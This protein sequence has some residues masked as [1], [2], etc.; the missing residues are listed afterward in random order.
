MDPSGSY[1]SDVEEDYYSFF[2]LSKDATEDEITNAYKRLSRVF[3]PDK[4]T[5]PRKK[6]NAEQLFHKTKTIYEVLRDPRK[7][8]I[9]DT[10]GV[11]G[12]NVD[13]WEVVEK[14]KSPEQIRAE[15]QRLAWLE[16]ERQLLQATNPRSTVVLNFNASDT[17]S[18]AYLDYEFEDDEYESFF[19]KVEVSG[20]SFS[21]SI[22]VPMSPEDTVC[23]TGNLQTNNGIG[24]GAINASL[25]RMRSPGGYEF[26]FGIGDGLIASAKGFRSFSSRSYA[27]LTGDCLFTSRGLSPGFVASTSYQFDDAY[28]GVWAW[29]GGRQSGMTLTLMRNTVLNSSQ[30]SLHLGI[31][32]VYT[33]LSSTWKMPQRD[34]KIKAGIKGGTFGCIIE[35]SFE[36]KISKYTAIGM[37]LTVG[38]PLG[39]SVRLRFIR[40]TQTYICNF[41]LCDEVMPIPIA[42][43]VVLPTVG[44]LAFKQLFLDKYKKAAEERDLKLWREAHAARLREQREEA[45]ATIVLLRETYARNRETEISK[46]GLVITK[47]IYGRIDEE[48]GKLSTMEGETVDVTIPLQ[49]LVKDSQLVSITSSKAQ[50][51]GFYDPCVGGRKALEI[52]YTFR[53]KPHKV[54][55][56]DNQRIRLPKNG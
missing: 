25:R 20:M 11:K 38:V 36:K 6:E 32:S 3:H 27:T 44:Y 19:P 46:H 31:A 54:F 26:G 52:E 4:H 2:N 23:L 47:A 9:Y 17:F 37:S 53:N 22:E 7:R 10:L 34:A 56:E 28:Q 45:E 51:P 21:Q 8:A 30:I 50:L 12:L 16:E 35:G 1:P 18:S 41:M 14:A 40:S 43:G 29:K 42:Y 5:D 49:C 15:Y 13:G 39:V 24:S 55:V 33:A 48:S